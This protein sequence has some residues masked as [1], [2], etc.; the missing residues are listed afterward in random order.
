MADKTRF[1]TVFLSD[2]DGV[3]MDWLGGFIKYMASIGHTALHDQPTEFSM[4]DIFPTCEKPWVHIMDYQH[5][6]F[7][8]EIKAYSD[9]INVY[10]NLHDSG[11][12]VI[13]VTSCGDTDLIK[14]VRTQVLNAELG[15][16]FSSIHF[17]PLGADKT[18]LLKSFEAGVF[19]DDQMKVAMN[20]LAGGH[21]C[22]LKDM[23]YNQYDH[24]EEVTRISNFEELY[25]LFGLTEQL[26]LVA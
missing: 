9:A 4:V 7:Y 2:V 3:L 24:D 20:G 17:L 19:I 26:E 6:A 21:T 23:P 18:E 11:V 12:E 8:C 13:F 25:E 10:K 5:S 22:L 15:G 14:Q 16:K 1:P